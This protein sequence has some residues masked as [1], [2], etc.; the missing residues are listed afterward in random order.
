MTSVDKRSLGGVDVSR[1]TFEA[2]EVYEAMVRRWNSAI[3]LVSKSSLPDLWA[4]HIEDSAQVLKLGPSTAAVW[5]DLGSGGGFPGL[6]V[7]ILA[8][9]LRP[10]LRVVLVEADIRKA[11]F[12]RQVV[13]TL[14]LSCTVRSE[15][16]ESLAQLEADVVSARALKAL[17][18]LLGYA[19]KHLR[20][21]GVAIFPKGARFRDELSQARETWDF[22]VD[23]EPSLA[24]PEAAILVIRN[25]HRHV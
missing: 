8:K 23:I 15:R 4:R 14:G 21:G 10:A 3:N 1:E 6:V 20:P 19:E 16:I 25:I 9:E 13:Q 11:V 24:D 12:L 5:A 7:A 22:D 17:P 2:L 18:D